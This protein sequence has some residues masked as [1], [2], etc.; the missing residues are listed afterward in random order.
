MSESYVSTASR[1][2]PQ[3]QLPDDLQEPIAIIGINARIPG[4]NDLDTHWENLLHGRQLLTEVPP[5]RW[6]W[7]AIYGDPET[8]EKTRANRA[9]F[10]EDV[11]KF[12][13][14][15]FG[16]SPREAKLMDPQ[17]RLSL[18]SAWLCIED[19]GYAPADLAGS[20]TG[21]FIGVSKSD[22]EELLYRQGIAVE[23]GTSTGVASSIIPNRIS[24]VLGLNGPSF[25]IDTACSGSLIALHTACQALRAKDC[26][27]A[28]AAGVHVM[29]T[30]TLTISFD[31]A[32]MLSPESRSKA[33]DA[34]A[35]GYARGEGVV[36]L[37]LKPLAQAQF[38]GDN[39]YGVV[40]G[41][42]AAHGGQTNSLTAP[43]A[44]V[45]KKL[46]K[47]VWSRA[48]I[49]P[50]TITYIEAHGTGTRLGDP[51][52]FSAIREA[53]SEA[54]EDF[55]PV[56]WQPACAI[57]SV[58]TNIGHLEA[59]AGLAGVLSVL[60]GFRHGIIPGNPNL[61]DVNEYCRT[62]GTPFYFPDS[63]R[64]WLR[65]NQGVDSLIPRRAGVSSFG[66]GGAY[67]HV[68]LEEAAPAAPRAAVEVLPVLPL[69]A[70]DP[71]ALQAQAHAAMQLINAELKCR[72]LSENIAQTL[73]EL[74]NSIAG[75]AQ[76]PDRR[77]RFL[78]AVQVAFK[79]KVP[80]TVSVSPN[81]LEACV[82]WL[83][84][85]DWSAA[86]S[87]RWGSI[88]STYQVG[89]NELP[90][91][92]AVIAAD[93]QGLAD[94][95]HAIFAGREHANVIGPHGKG[96]ST[97]RTDDHDLLSLAGKFAQRW[98]RGEVG[99]KTLYADSGAPRAPLPG[100]PFLRTRHW[101]DAPAP[102]ES[103]SK[104][105]A[106]DHTPLPTAFVDIKALKSAPAQLSA[107][108]PI[109]ANVGQDVV[110]MTRPAQGVV[111]LELAE[112][113]QANMFTSALTGSLAKHF[114]D[115]ENDHSVRAVVVTGSPRVF[116]MGGTPDWLSG[117]ARG[118]R[119]FTDEPF[120]YKGFLSSR[121]PVISALQGHAFGGGLL[122]GL[123]AD[124]PILSR[125]ALYAANFMEYGFTPG[126][127]TTLVLGEKLGRAL[128]TEMMFSAQ[129]Y[130]GA[131]LAARGAGVLIV[132]SAEVLPRALEI[133]KRIAA[134]PATS[135][136]EL[137]KELAGALLEKLEPCIAREDAM[138]RRVMASPEILH[139]VEERFL[140]SAAV[141][142]AATVT[143]A[144][145]ESLAAPRQIPLTPVSAV[146]QPAALP[147]GPA[148]IQLRTL[149]SPA[150]EQSSGA[151]KNR[152]SHLS[153]VMQLLAGVLQLHRDEY[154]PQ[155]P[156]RDLG[157]DSINS[158][159]FARALEGQ[160]GERIDRDRLRHLDCAQEIANWLDGQSQAHTA[161][162]QVERPVS[163][164]APS[165]PVVTSA[166]SFHSVLEV[167]VEV[168]GKIL[169]LAPEDYDANTPFRDL[170]LDSIN[171]IE[172]VRALDSRFVSL[173]GHYNSNA[174]QALG[175]AQAL[176]VDLAARLEPSGNS[177]E[178]KGVASKDINE[179]LDGVLGGTMSV[180][181]A[182]SHL[183]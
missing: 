64:P 117:I 87:Q 88:L 30:P 38:D 69:S 25:P 107:K 162:T 12:D 116:S 155:T 93:W 144:A 48:G 122:L 181:I 157:L 173:A 91:R 111:Q 165:I 135:A 70:K 146:V 65:L 115:V 13:A 164:V 161:V 63:A 143:T 170:G 28:L 55:A 169:H 9:G 61:H 6:D 106:T 148:K 176:A 76:S 141:A 137:K 44:S 53:F 23:A 167:V 8:S 89:R 171:A 166:P 3:N 120:L 90:L 46:L 113:D 7:S 145:P 131:E 14:R 101:F 2:A 56:S 86:S 20:E 51:I 96:Q 178:P 138:H 36:T 84:A 35:D 102:V 15:F 109:A 160:L 39:I 60:L 78:H 17:Q 5:S 97:Q 158:I 149:H 19:A 104:T 79:V 121:V 132:P 154:T 85:Y 66:F 99:F 52:E 32:G 11:D 175:T 182:L 150:S 114:A 92:I 119:S 47:R 139:R 77:A 18:E 103:T 125:E 41:S 50:R 110:R 4:A 163:P 83:T 82:A 177:A 127:G 54:C 57:G 126:M 80:D 71:A 152:V 151:G 68:L 130:A 142:A 140:D 40:R 94:G 128:A 1:H 49:D 31:K 24:Y 34:S 147:S 59:A 172:L 43:N 153:M 156:L 26:T 100:Y 58:K 27:M 75:D 174:L 112:V 42:G 29:L 73:H 72:T 159:E 183:A 123:Y 95:L 179:L 118:E 62:Q 180:D 33:F 129:S 22:Y 134:M 10:I 124:V 105:V 81:I 37:L 74:M 67:A 108:E 45:Q 136:S 16:I 168:L 98:V 21:V 133:A